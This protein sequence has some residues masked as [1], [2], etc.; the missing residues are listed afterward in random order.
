MFA[1]LET[2]GKQYKVEEG[3]ILEI[4]LLTEEKGKKLDKYVFENVLLLKG[5]TTQLGT[6][7]VKNAKVKA[8]ILEEIK[9]PK[10][11]VFKKKSKKQYKKTQGHRQR[12]HKILIEKIEVKADPKPKTKPAVEKKEN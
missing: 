3:D 7:Y 5:E 9:A 6:P 12:L 8:K 2:G 1:I 4:E 11:I 10:I